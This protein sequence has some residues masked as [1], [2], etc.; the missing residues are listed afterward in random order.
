LLAAVG[1]IAIVAY[2]RRADRRLLAAM[3]LISA[4]YVT[5]L[6]AF[7][8][9]HGIWCPPARYLTTLVPLAAAPLAAALSMLGHRRLFCGVYSVLAAAGVVFMQVIMSD[10]RMMWPN[11]PLFLWLRHVPPPIL[12]VDLWDRLP[13]FPPPDNPLLPGA[14]GSVVG[15]AFGVVVLCSLPLLPSPSVAGSGR[16]QVIVHGLLVGTSLLA[17][18]SGWYLMNHEYLQPGTHPVQ[19]HRDVG[20]LQQPMVVTYPD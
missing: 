1:V 19:A 9:W 6:A 15:F 14:S 11:Y 16:R 10:A 4:P 12:R 7:E 8:F 18:A 2:G 5:T 3:A 13:A 17:L 20:P